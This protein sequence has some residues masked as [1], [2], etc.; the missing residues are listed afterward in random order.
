MRYSNLRCFPR[1]WCES[2][3]HLTSSSHLPS[4]CQWSNLSSE[5]ARFISRQQR[6]SCS[7]WY[8][9]CGGEDQVAEN[10]IH[11]A[12]PFFCTASVPAGWQCW[13]KAITFSGRCSVA[14]RELVL[15]ASS[16]RLTIFAQ[17]PNIISPLR[18]FLCNQ[19]WRKRASIGMNRRNVRC[20]TSFPSSALLYRERVGK[21][22]EGGESW[23]RHN[24]ELTSTTTV[25]RRAGGQEINWGEGE[26]SWRRPDINLCYL[27]CKSWDVLRVIWLIEIYHYCSQGSIEELVRYN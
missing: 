25:R 4:T 11:L 26:H 27:L 15:P 21:D 23:L 14:N 3:P 7:V 2:S 13:T 10:T 9:R 12:L 18:C 16:A 19:R 5:K 17:P 8:S 6:G 24:S 20:A 22:E 1:T